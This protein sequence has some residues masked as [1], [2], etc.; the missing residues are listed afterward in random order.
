[1]RKLST[2]A[3]LTLVLLLGSVG[4]SWG[5]DFQKGYT[6][7][8]SGDYA[9]ALR[10]WTPLAEQGYAAAQSNLG[11]MFENG[12]GVPK[13]NKTAV[14][15]Y[16]LAAEGYADA[17]FN[18]GVM[19]Y[20]GKGV[21]KD[22]RT[23][24]KWYTLAAEQGIASAQYNLGLMCDNG[25]GVPQDDETAV[26]WYTLAAK[27][28]DADAQS[29]LGVMYGTGKGVIQDYVYAHVWLSIAASSREGGNASKNRDIIA[30]RMIPTQIDESQ[31]LARECVRKNYKGC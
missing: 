21:P 14:K 28:G 31:R 7:Y 29:N 20:N 10:K 25:E 19:Y 15:W 11:Y 3:C 24:V 26:K 12:K 6:A 5:A 27:Q 9:T 16:R 18:L 4:V 30:K 23:A 22:D 13:D 1:M 2:T 8:E 17:Q